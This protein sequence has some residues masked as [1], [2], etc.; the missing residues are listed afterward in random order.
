[1]SVELTVQ[2]VSKSPAVPKNAEFARWAE[3]CFQEEGWANAI[4]LR[5]VDE[6]ESEQLN[7]RYRGKHAPTNVLSFP[8]GLPEEVQ[9]AIKSESGVLLLGD[10]VICAGVVNAE[11]GLQNKVASEHWAH[12]VVHGILHLLGHDHQEQYQAQE[13]ERLE[14]DILS[15][16]EIS[17]PYQ[18]R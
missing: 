9:R 6:A 4:T 17:D 5:I 11:A 8:S 12:M 10:L 16:L 13:M 15:R 7:S 14:K 3:A 2:R 18:P 1:M